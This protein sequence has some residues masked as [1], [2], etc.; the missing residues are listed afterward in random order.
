LIAMVLIIGLPQ[1]S[2]LASKFPRLPMMGMLYKSTLL[3][4]LPIGLITENGAN[5]VLSNMQRMTA[6]NSSA[7][8][9]NG[10]RS[11]KRM[12]GGGVNRHTATV[13]KRLPHKTIS[14]AVMVP[15]IAKSK[16]TIGSKIARNGIQRRKRLL[17]VDR[18][19]I[20][21][22][23]IP[24]N[25]IAPNA[26]TAPD[27]ITCP[28]SVKTGS[29]AVTTLTI[30]LC[31]RIK[32]KKAMASEPIEAEKIFV[33]FA[34]V[35]TGEGS[36]FAEADTLTI[37]SLGF[38]VCWSKCSKSKIWPIAFPPYLLVQIIP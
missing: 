19:A 33:N 15:E 5:R 25:K 38:I 6:S 8:A 2:I 3:I 34:I 20:I 12:R 9:R 16:A 4:M 29:V 7:V 14:D 36:W 27:K 18:Q 17:G 24:V 22:S 21:A 32:K 26:S 31:E 35:G 13:S 10:M 11:N 30:E 37:L 1:M 28:A 23:G